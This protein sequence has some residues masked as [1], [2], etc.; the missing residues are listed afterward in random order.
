M[1]LDSLKRAAAEEALGLVR[2]GMVLGLGTGST[3]R[4]LVDALAEALDD[5]RL[6]DIVGVPTSTRTEAQARSLGVPLAALD[7]HPTLDL[8][9][10]GADEVDPQL[11]LIKGL[12]AALLREK[13]VAQASQRLVII[14]DDSK[15]VERLGQ[16]APLP[17]EVVDWA[18]DAQSAFLSGLGADVSLRVDRDGAP[19]RSD[20][21]N[22]FLDARFEGGLPDPVELERALLY[23]AGVVD[24][25]L[26]L[27]MADTAFIAS[28]DGVTALHRPGGAS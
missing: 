6:K 16:K 12:G 9:I 14:S 24:T 17:V 25:G 1:T 21:G 23:R 20:N 4:H 27:G 2:D 15:L 11:D 18:L 7:T 26:F 28:E 22:V 8:T 13:M 3:V 10:D 5:G 19:I